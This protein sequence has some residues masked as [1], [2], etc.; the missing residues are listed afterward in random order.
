M[1]NK[2]LVYKNLTDIKTTI[3]GCK[4]NYKQREFLEHIRELDKLYRFDS[5][6]FKEIKTILDNGIY[7]VHQK[8]KLNE[9]RKVYIS[10]KKTGYIPISYQ[11][12][13]PF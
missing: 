10:Y 2:Y 7:Q 3:Q 4:L 11:P 13:L 1:N 5:H 12:D 6:Y 8:E 9:I